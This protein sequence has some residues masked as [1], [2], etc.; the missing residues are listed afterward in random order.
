M[1]NLLKL[2]FDL[3]YR[4]TKPPWDSGITPPEVVAFVLA[5]K[6]RGRA[7]DV[8]CGTGTNSIYLTQQGFAVVGLDFSPK[9]IA[10][11]R[12]KAKYAGLAIDLQVADV[13]QLNFLRGPFEYILDIG[14]LHTLDEKGRA[15]YAEHLAR[16]AKPGGTFMLYAFNPRP[17]NKHGLGIRGRS[18]GISAEQVTRLLSPS[19]GLERIEH[20]ADRGARTSAWY[21]FKRK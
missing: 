5:T 4:F 9:A 3:R 19:F 20:G 14:C 2:F 10:L 21:W 13:T 18:S 16:L 15:Q 7:L 6:E 17:E 1:F 12:A 11:A 8:G